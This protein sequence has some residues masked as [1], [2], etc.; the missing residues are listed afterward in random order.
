MAKTLIFVTVEKVVYITLS[1]LG[2]SSVIYLITKVFVL[3]QL[4]GNLI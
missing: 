1:I 4:V 2:I 3:G